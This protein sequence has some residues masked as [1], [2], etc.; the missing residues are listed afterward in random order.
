MFRAV[1]F[2]CLMEQPNTFLKSNNSTACP[3]NARVGV[4]H[5]YVFAHL[6]LIITLKWKVV[7]SWVTFWNLSN[8]IKM[9]SWKSITKIPFPTFAK[10][11]EKVGIDILVID[12][13]GNIFMN[14][15]EFQNLLN[16]F[17]FNLRPHS[18][19]YDLPC[20]SYDQSKNVTVWQSYVDKPS[21]Y[22]LRNSAIN[23]IL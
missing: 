6:A 17:L 15:D 23:L 3:R 19:L 16:K 1:I 14:S 10:S 9:F 22:L 5:R 7:E 13:Q 11:S 18:T 4:S 21:N 12:F 8:L 20:Q 2:F